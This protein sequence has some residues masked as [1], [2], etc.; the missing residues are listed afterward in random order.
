MAPLI[1]LNLL[2]GIIQVSQYLSMLYIPQMFFKVAGKPNNYQFYLPKFL[3]VF[4]NISH[5]LLRP[6]Q[7]LEIFPEILEW[8]A[9]QL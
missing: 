1:L 6:I 2:N 8:S 5:K 3:E 4:D 7:F 9:L